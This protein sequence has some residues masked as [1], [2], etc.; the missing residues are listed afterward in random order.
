MTPI[1]CTVSSP[2]EHPATGLL[3]TPGSMVV[4]EEQ[5]ATLIAAGLA[6]AE[7]LSPAPK[8]RTAAAPAPQEGE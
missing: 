4:T 3:L 2:C 7:Q 5:A 1:V 6:T 8:R